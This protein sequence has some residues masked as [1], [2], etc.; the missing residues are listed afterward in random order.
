MIRL[1]NLKKGD[2]GRI[3][4]LAKSDI[5]YRRKLL[6][7]G[8]TPGV[9]FEIIR[10]APLG[11]PLEISLRGYQLSLRK[12]EADIILVERYEE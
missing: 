4:A 12:N 1:A 10:V 6:A 9:N 11:D 7:M 2:Q 3:L 5:A 8:L